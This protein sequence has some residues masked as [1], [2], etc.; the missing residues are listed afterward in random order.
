M[1]NR[2][3][4][5]YYP[6]KNSA[7][8]EAEGKA[9]MVGPDIPTLLARAIVLLVAFTIH[10]LAHAVTADYLGD[11][12][13][14]RM[15][16][17]TLNP[18]AHLDPFGTIMLLISGFGWA[19]PVMVNPMNLRGNPRTSM[20]IVAAA[21]PLSNLSLAIL[22]AIPVRL[23]LIEISIGTVGTGL[24][25][26]FLVYQFIMINLILLFFNLIPIPPLDGYKIL[27]GILPYEMAYQLRPLEQYGFLILLVAIFVLPRVGIDVLGFLVI[28]PTFALYSLL[29]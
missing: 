3:T 13:P 1:K 22:F 26:E 20:A 4:S 12:T 5:V 10:E 28:Q 15:G 27:T 11:P 21:G 8:L 24:S 7:S 16:R 29:T 25:L 19:K 2:A 17:I 14:R 6:S 18:L 23:G 9:S